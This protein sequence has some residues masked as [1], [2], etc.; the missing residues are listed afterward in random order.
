[1]DEQRAIELLSAC[2]PL[3]AAIDSSNRGIYFQPTDEQLNLLKGFEEVT[4]CD[5][6]RLS[7]LWLRDMRQ[8]AGLRP[9]DLGL[10]QGVL[11]QQYM[12]RPG[13]ADDLIESLKRMLS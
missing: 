3:I 2:K 5:E 6:A 9:S 8:R 4:T 12:S 1:M 10:L 7:D 11:W 13:M